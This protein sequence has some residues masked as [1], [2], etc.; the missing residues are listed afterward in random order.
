MQPLRVVA[1]RS[2][3]S[4]SR[5][6]LPYPTLPLLVCRLASD[7][8]AGGVSADLADM[9]LQHPVVVLDTAFGLGDQGG[10]PSL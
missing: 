3:V 5:H 8:G 1:E 2:L 10:G 4:P 6:T 9:P 7:P